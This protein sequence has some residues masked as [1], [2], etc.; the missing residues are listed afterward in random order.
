MAL[1]VSEI[2]ILTTHIFIKWLFANSCD[3]PNL[4]FYQIYMWITIKRGRQ[5]NGHEF[6][7]LKSALRGSKN[8]SFLNGA[9]I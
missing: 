9:Y 1:L 8:I 2:F 4:T 5:M 6:I 7:G 3:I